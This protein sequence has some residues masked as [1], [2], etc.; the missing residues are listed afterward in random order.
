MEDESQSEIPPPALQ[1]PVKEKESEVV[2]PEVSEVK[3]E[4][5]VKPE[6]EPSVH[7][8]DSYEEEGEEEGEDEEDAEEE[9]E[10]E[11]EE[12]EDE[13]EDQD[14]FGSNRSQS[15]AKAGEDEEASSDQEKRQKAILRR[16]TRARQRKLEA[17]FMNYEVLDQVVASTMKKFGLRSN[18]PGPTTVDP[19]ILLVLSEGM[20][21]KYS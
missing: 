8:E 12:G 4:S 14:L 6:E 16:E 5:A 9:G 18:S 15:D 1:T 10:D 20:K 13:M 11:M 21:I 7:G 19:E 17:M 3:E 2:N